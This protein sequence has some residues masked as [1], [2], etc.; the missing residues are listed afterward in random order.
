MST[1]IVNSYNI[2]EDKG[3]PE[4]SPVKSDLVATKDAE[5]KGIEF[6]VSMRSYTQH[7]MEELI[8]EA[9]ARMLVGKT[10]DHPLAKQ[11]EAKCV[12]LITAKADKALAAVT[13]DIIDQ[14]VMPKFPFMVK[15]DEKPVTMREFI[16]L[17]GQAY[18]TARVNRSG[19]VTTDNYHA[20]PRIQYLVE[21]FMDAKFKSEIEKA[22]NA[23]IRDIQMQIHARHNTFLE[24][25]KTRVRDALAKL[26]PAA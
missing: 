6:H 1:E 16:G 17:T 18:L 24:A 10:K 22:T 15:A 2:A 14:P 26:G 11:I 13:S 19:E 7:D 23:A 9:A 3:D 12:E 25:E 21:R 8:V 5:G 20:Q 4:E